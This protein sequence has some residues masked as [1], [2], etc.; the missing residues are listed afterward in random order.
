MEPGERAFL[1]KLKA[2][3]R[4]AEDRFDNE[5]RAKTLV[6]LDAVIARIVK[7]H[8]PVEETQAY[9]GLRLNMTI[10]EGP[11]REDASVLAAQ[12]AA[13]VRSLGEDEADKRDEAAGRIAQDQATMSVSS[14][15]DCP[16]TGS[17]TAAEAMAILRAM[18]KKAG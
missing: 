15:P 11:A 2:L 7:A 13:L 9:C 16:H 3:R 18:V 5:L 12:A 17:Q 4:E 8:A 14:G 1:E 6:A 10:S